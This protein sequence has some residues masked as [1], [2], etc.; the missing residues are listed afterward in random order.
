[1]TSQRFTTRDGVH[2]HYLEAGAE[3]HGSVL[4]ILP[5]WTSAASLYRAQLEELGRTHRVLAL[6]YRGHG[7]SEKPEHGYRVSRLAADVRE[8]I[9]SL[10]LNDMV[11][12]GHSAGCAVIWSYVDLFGEDGLRGL[13]FFDQM[14]ARVRRKEWSE[15]EARRYG[16]EVTGD[17]VLGQAAMVADPANRPVICK[18]IESMVTPSCPREIVDRIV[19]YHYLVPRTAAAELLLSVSFSFY[20]DVLSRITVPTLCLGGAA[21]HI[22][23]EVMPFIASRLPHGRVEMIAEDE[24]GSHYA[25]LE[26]P[27]LFNAKVRHFWDSL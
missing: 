15:G 25:F 19:E 12:L 18:F 4:L 9:Q 17:E 5:G 26:N 20:L 7:G 10:G 3:H 14:L 13:I 27:V 23:R 21:S 22:N 1:M 6:D 8:L 11:L 2:L 24:G 16:T